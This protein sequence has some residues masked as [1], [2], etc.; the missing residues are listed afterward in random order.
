MYELLKEEMI[1]SV[2][3]RQDTPHRRCSN[4]GKMVG[5]ANRVTLLLHLNLP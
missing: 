1:L 4:P 2:F 5:P 3:L